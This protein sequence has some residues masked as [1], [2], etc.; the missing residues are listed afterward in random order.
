MVQNLSSNVDLY[1][2]FNTTTPPVWLDES[3][4]LHLKSKAE[5]NPEAHPKA[6]P[7]SIHENQG[8]Q[9]VFQALTDRVKQ[10]KSGT[11]SPRFHKSLEA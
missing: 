3:K 6:L 5:L 4:M 10:L 7:F 8:C 1:C 9:E 2:I 11:V